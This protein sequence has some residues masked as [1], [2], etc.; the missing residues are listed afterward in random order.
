M[1]Y[2]QSSGSGKRSKSRLS[3][4]LNAQIGGSEDMFG[5]V[6]FREEEDVFSPKVDD[7][8]DDSAERYD[9]DDDAPSKKKRRSDTAPA[10]GTKNSVKSKKKEKLRARGPLDPALSSGT[11]DAVP[12]SVRDAEAAADDIFG[13]LDETEFDAAAGNGIEDEDAYYEWLESSKKK[14]RRSAT[15]STKTAPKRRDGAAHSEADSEEENETGLDD[16]I[17]ATAEDEDILEQLKE[18]RTR[19]MAV[20]SGEATGDEMNGEAATLSDSKKAAIEIT[21]AAVDAYTSLLRVRVKLQ[22]IVCKMVQFPQYYALP[23]FKQHDSKVEVETEAMSATLRDVYHELAE[24]SRRSFITDEG[25]RSDDHP[26]GVRGTQYA[27][28]AKFHNAALNRANETINYWSSRVVQTNAAKL[29]SVNQPLVDQIRAIVNAKARLLGRVQRN[30]LH[31]K[32]Y[33]HP[34]HVKSSTAADRANAIAAGDFDDEIFD[35]GDFV[36]ELVHRSGAAAQKLEA[37][38]KESE[39][40]VVASL[41]SAAAALRSSSSKIGFHRKTKGKSVNYDPRPKLVGFMMR[42]PCEDASGQPEHFEALLKSLFQ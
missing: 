13:L 7:F 15:V 21:K 8:D 11:Y 1:S 23:A 31:A 24:L 6:G 5:D 4:A 12:V 37:S 36:R 32:I 29:K 16:V 10:G 25:K 14:K 28:L 42:T 2:K 22:P 19:Q 33:G 41:D 39:G 30:R 18:L 40:G 27:A 20:V 34:E 9:D 26:E 17:P 3:D 35:D 38:L